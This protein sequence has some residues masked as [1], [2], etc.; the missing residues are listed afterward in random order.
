MLKTVVFIALDVLVLLCQLYLNNDHPTW[1]VLYHL[2]HLSLHFITTLHHSN[3]LQRLEHVTSVKHHLLTKMINNRKSK[4][5]DSAESSTMPSP[6][7]KASPLRRPT[8]SWSFEETARDRNARE[9][10]KKKLE[11]LSS[12]E[13]LYD[14]LT[15]YMT[16]V[17]CVLYLP[18]ALGERTVFS[19]YFLTLFSTAWCSV[20]SYCLQEG[21]WYTFFICLGWS[22]RISHR[23]GMERTVSFNEMIQCMEFDDTQVSPSPL[24]GKITFVDSIT[25][26]R[27]S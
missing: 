9:E 16:L 21:C 11:E 22:G 3:V 7:F 1:S 19:V 2:S 20:I 15:C 26:L 18:L 14:S 4:V 23:R 6:H 13:G 10:N 5:P 25:G 8:R 27:S 12:N 24:N 17:C